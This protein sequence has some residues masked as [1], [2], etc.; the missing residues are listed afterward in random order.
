VEPCCIALACRADG[1]PAWVIDYSNTP[2]TGGR[3]MAGFLDEMRTVSAGQCA[4]M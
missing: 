2:A 4:R 3:S 1:K